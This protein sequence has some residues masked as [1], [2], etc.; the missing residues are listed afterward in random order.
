MTLKTKEIAEFGD[1]QTPDDLASEAC[2]LLNRQEVRPASIL[3]PTCGRGSFLFAALDTFPSIESAIGLDVNARYIEQANQRLHD[4]RDAAKAQFIH[5]NFFETHWRDLIETLPE[6]ILVLGNPP[7]VTNAHLGALGSGNLPAKTN[8]KKHSG[9][10]A[11]T[12]K[13]NF[14]ISEW[15]LIRMLEWL[16]GRSGTIAM[17]CKSAVARK[18]LTHAW[19]HDFPVGEAA[20]YRIDA[21]YHFDAAVEAAFLV[22]DV[23][24]HAGSKRAHIYEHLSRT[25]RA[26]S[27][28][29]ADGELIADLDRYARQKHLQGRTEALTWRSGVKHDCAKIMELR[30]EGHQYRNGLGELVQL[31]D[32]YLYPMLKSSEVAGGFTSE[33]HRWMLVTQKM[34]GQETE[35]IQD[36]AP[37]TWAYLNRHRALLARRGSSIYKNRPPFSIFGVG[38]YSFSPWKVAISGFYKKLSFTSLGSFS[39]KPIVLDDTCYFLPCETQAQA[40]LLTKL[41]NSN[42]AAEFFQAF[43]FWDAKRPITAELLRRLNLRALAAACGAEDELLRHFP[44]FA[45]GHKTKGRNRT[46]VTAPKELW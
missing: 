3:E 31:E 46:N 9:V 18:A 17:L 14:D 38:D 24:Q 13:S 42:A 1:F 40:E 25:S 44:A 21:D 28:G 36:A 34:V 41:L 10:D 23:Q 37:L 35:G 45:H 26:R 19:K 12:G 2:A 43:V 4:R 20:I 27:I 11:I 32:D 8:F 6:P 33:V 16:D 5:A 30:R 29:F 7:W 15:M 22:F 39:G